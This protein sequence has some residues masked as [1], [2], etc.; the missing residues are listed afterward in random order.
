[1]A[2]AP[3]TVLRWHRDI[4]RRRWAGRSRRERPG[5]RAT[6]RNIRDLVLRLARE[7][8]GWGYRRIH[9][10]LTGLGIRLA[11]VDLDAF[12]CRRR[13][14]IGGVTHEYTHVA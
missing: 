9:G 10:E 8:P 1:M 13:D 5:R 4:V 7:N 12:R 3:A 14:L 11:L 2:V 6:R